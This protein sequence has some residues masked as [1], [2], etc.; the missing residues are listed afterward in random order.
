MPASD[1]DVKAPRLDEVGDP[2]LTRV[3]DLL[4]IEG[5]GRKVL[6]FGH[7]RIIVS[8]GPVRRL[9]SRDWVVLIIVPETDFVGFVA[10]SGVTALVMSVGV[11]LI[12]AAL[13]GLLAWRNVQAERRAAAATTRQQALETRTQTFIDLAHDAVAAD[14]EEAGLARATESA[15]TRL[16]RQARGDL[17]AE[18]R[19][20]HAHLRRLLRQHRERPHRGPRA[21]SRRDAQPVRRPG[22]G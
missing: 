6:D 10:D 13:T 11:V 1:P 18:P 12:V 8:S 3:Y 15:A 17:A 20:P 4:R 5:Y 21:P 7:E 22:K 16:R 14:A 19:W 9:T 2:V